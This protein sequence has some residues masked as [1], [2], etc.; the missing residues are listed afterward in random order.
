MEKI[1]H[2]RWTRNNGLY[3]VIDGFCVYN[4]S[5]QRTKT[6][7]DFNF[8][9]NFYASALR[10]ITQFTENVLRIRVKLSPYEK[11][12]DEHPTK[13]N[14]HNIHYQILYSPGHNCDIIISYAYD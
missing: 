6:A 10:Q 1:N 14:F 13:C 9:L 4:L 8:V 5:C 12:T 7:I 2:S 3:R 11:H